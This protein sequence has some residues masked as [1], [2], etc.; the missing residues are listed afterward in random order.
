MYEVVWTHQFANIIG[1]T[2]ESMAAVFSIFLICLALGGHLAGKIQ[3]LQRYP[4][5]TYAV[6]ELAIGLL[7]ALSSLFLL[8]FED[9]ALS[10]LQ[11]SDNTFLR[12]LVQIGFVMGCIGPATVLMGG[13]LPVIMEAAKRWVL[14]S[15]SVT[16]LYGLNTAGAAVGALLP[17]L[18]LVPRFGLSTTAL[19][20]MAVNWVAGGLALLLWIW[21]RKVTATL[22][23]AIN[24]DPIHKPAVPL[25]RTSLSTGWFLALS[26]IS[27]FNVLSLE[28]CWG[29]LSRFVLG[30]RSLAISALLCGVLLFLGLAS[31][32][33]RPLL[34]YAQQRFS[35]NPDRCLAIILVSSG[36]F[37]LLLAATAVRIAEA[38]PTLPGLALVVFLAQLA[39]PFFTA[40][41]FFPWLLM[42]F[43]T[44]DTD[45]GSTVGR[46][47]AANVVG[48]TLGSGV[49]TF[50]LVE[51]VGT[52]TTLK[53]NSALFFVLGIVLCRRFFTNSSIWIPI[54]GGLMV[55]M[56][57]A[58]LGYP[59]YILPL[60]PNEELLEVTEDRYGIQILS[61]DATGLVTATNNN[62]RLVAKF[63][64]A[65]TTYAQ[66]MQADIP[67]LLAGDTAHLLN[68]GTGFG[69]TSGAFTLW[70]SHYQSLV[71]IEILP[72]MTRHQPD[73][74]SENYAFYEKPKVRLITG[75]GRRWLTASKS[76]Y[77][78]ISVNPLDPRLPG[79]ASLCTVDFWKQAKAKLSPHGVYTQLVWGPQTKMLVQGF[80]QVFPKFMMVRSYQTSYVLIGMSN[81]AAPLPEF[82]FE[83]LTPE[84]RAAYRRFGIEDCETFFAVLRDVAMRDTAEWL[85]EIKRNPEPVLHSNDR[86]VLEYLVHQG[87]SAFRTPD[88][89]W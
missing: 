65:N 53:I 13:T 85:E 1:G 80:S 83:R 49:T 5:L 79:S 3:P 38:P 58:L 57:V 52:L 77:D 73:F 10:L 30:N 66:H 33:C 70:G 47:Y 56:L 59:R 82:H 35:F 20:A 67:M 44:L 86:P 25:E 37:Q 71:S 45:T 74:A 61:R 14:P 4:L 27:G 22:P 63:G 84:V 55:W 24:T 39:L 6:M 42:N 23:E 34:K 72:F 60:P 41:L 18:I 75:D 28:M 2:T 16:L 19:T 12:I 32:W 87:S 69:I 51:T 48:S 50:V 76:Q 68:V 7:G 81:D 11:Q 46:L 31:L 54:G 21:D 26:A 64:A 78:I 88:E 62:V 43:P 15:R 8:R 29:R 40:G 89:N 17:G 9:L 36:L